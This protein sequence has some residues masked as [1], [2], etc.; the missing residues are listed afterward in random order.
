VL[1]PLR[2][3]GC[4]L[5]TARWTGSRCRT[6]G[7]DSAGGAEAGRCLEGL[8]ADAAAEEPCDDAEGEPPD[9]NAP[10]TAPLTAPDAAPVDQSDD[11]LE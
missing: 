11:S 2:N 4:Q 9:R 5:P 10:L 8:L 6:S 1:A 3:H 7:C